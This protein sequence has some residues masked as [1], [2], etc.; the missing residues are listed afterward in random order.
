[1]LGLPFHCCAHSSTGAATE[2]TTAIR[3]APLHVR[4]GWPATSCRRKPPKDDCRQREQLSVWFAAVRQIHN[5]VIA[6]YLQ[7]LLLTGARREELAGLAW[8]DVDFR[9]KS[10]AI[11]DKVDGERTIPLTPYVAS[12][13]AGLPRRNQWVFSS[14]LLPTGVFKSPGFSTRGR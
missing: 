7:A 14:Q 1:M 9:W 12:L 10:A 6:A 11:K 4:R 5:P 3:C 2:T 8:S 13:L